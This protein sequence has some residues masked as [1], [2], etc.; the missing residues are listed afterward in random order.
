MAEFWFSA[1]W[2][3][4]SPHLNLLDFSTGSVLRPK[5]QATP[6]ANLANTGYSG[7][8]DPQNMPLCSAAA[9]MPWLRKMKLKLTRWLAK[10]PAYTNQYFS[11]QT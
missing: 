10:G 11:G 8:I 6:H 5:G 2:P 3:P 9:V 4:Y 1:D 7:S